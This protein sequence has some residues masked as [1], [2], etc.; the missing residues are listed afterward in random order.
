MRSLAMRYLA[1]GTQAHGA[2]DEGNRGGGQATGT[3]WS[4]WNGRPS[5]A[6]IR[7]SSANVA[8]GATTGREPA[9][10]T[11]V[12]QRGLIFVGLDVHKDSISAGVLRPRAEV[13]EVERI[14]NDEELIRRFFG[15]F[16]QSKALRVCYEAGPTGFG[17]ARPWGTCAGLGRT[18]SM[19]A[20][21][22]ATAGCAVAAA[23]AH[24]R[25]GAAWTC[26]HEQWLAALRFGEPAL[27]ATLE[28]Y[29][30][31]LADRDAALAA[32]EADL[33]A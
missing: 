18:R 1:T 20:S 33:K 8:D 21:G 17:L 6:D 10:M 29:R 28:H 27:W 26:L 9:A 5:S 23:R 11:S 14:F 25:G 16:R 2:E 7:G 32:V 12:T 13:P 4:A 19:T 3:D 24:L 15:R 22:P 31:V 30:A